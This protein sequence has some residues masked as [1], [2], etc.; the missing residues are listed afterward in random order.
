[1]GKIE[2][3]LAALRAALEAESRP[4]KPE[5]GREATKSEET[6]KNEYQEANTE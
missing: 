5:A 3:V 4:L 2:K 6:P 1:M